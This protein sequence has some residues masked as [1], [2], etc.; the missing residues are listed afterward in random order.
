MAATWDPS[1]NSAV[2]R[3]EIRSSY[4]IRNAIVH[5]DGATEDQAMIALL[6]IDRN[7]FYIYVGFL[8]I[9]AIILHKYKPKE[10]KHLRRV[11]R[12]HFDEMKDA[13]DG[14]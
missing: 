6:N 4:K 2:I 5:G 13:S 14:I 7:I 8:R 12:S 10:L 9:Y 3:D 11:M 1:V